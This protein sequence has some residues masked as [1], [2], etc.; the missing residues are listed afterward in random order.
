MPLASSDAGRGGETLNQWLMMDDPAINIEDSNS[1]E[2]GE[3][4]GGGEPPS[5]G[6]GFATATILTVNMV[7]GAGV[8]GLPYAFYHAG[9]VISLISM[10]IATVMS[11]MTMGY[12]VEVSAWAH[13]MVKHTA[14]R[15][16]RTG[17]EGEGGSRGRDDAIAE[18]P[19]DVTELDAGPSS[20]KHE[21]RPAVD[22]EV[23]MYEM[24]ELCGIFLGGYGRKLFELCLLLYTIG[25]LWLYAT[26][27]GSSLSLV[28]PLPLGDRPT[29]IAWCLVRCDAVQDQACSGACRW[30]NMTAA[31]VAAPAV[32][33][34]CRQSYEVFLCF[35]ALLMV[36]MACMDLAALKN[37]QFLLSSFALS[38]LLVMVVT[39]VVAVYTDG[40]NDAA[41]HRLPPTDMSGFGKLITAA[42]FSQICHQGVPTLMKTMRSGKQ[43]K[44]VFRTALSF[45]L[46][47]YSVLCCST[48]Y[49]F[50]PRVV[51]I[52]TLNWEDYTGGAQAGMPIRW[53]APIISTTVLLF[54][55][56]SVSA[57][58][59]LNL[60]PL[61]ETILRLL[62]ARWSLRIGEER[63]R[64][65]LKIFLSLLPI[66][67][68]AFVKDVAKILEFNGM[69]GFVIAFF[70]PCSLFLVARS[71]CRKRFGEQAASTAYSSFPESSTFCV[72]LLLAFSVVLAAFTARQ[73]IMDYMS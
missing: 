7:V 26:V 30:D 20:S 52:I 55:V 32:A 16:E 37:V 65:L 43:A 53:W 62:P 44:T 17:E 6:F 42:L 36:A 71:T 70:A 14:G 27:F 45:T 54:P 59:P 49:Y 63:A 8:V 33:S 38:A 1:E 4:E 21:A 10:F 73:V 39:C 51:P 58:F 3:R 25:S 31:C 11:A 15:E 2:H 28:V 23:A 64:K 72:L 9:A 12:L 35:F 61:A 60:L 19:S 34:Y 56:V 24:S 13:Y 66:T 50:G 5:E 40:G 69:F 68:A 46:V 41:Y 47:L 57:A 22:R 29:S 48:I 67:L 18:L